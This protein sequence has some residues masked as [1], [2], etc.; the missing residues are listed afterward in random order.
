MTVRTRAAPSTTRFELSAKPPF[1]LDLTVWALRRRPRNAVDRWDDNT[2]R[3]ATLIGNTLA[4]VAVVQTGS[5]DAPR[6]AVTVTG[7]AAIEPAVARTAATSM[8]RRMLGLDTDLDDFYR[9]AA[10]DP[11]LSPL[12]RCFQGLKPPRFASLFEGRYRHRPRHGL[13]HA[14]P[15]RGARCLRG[16]ACDRLPADRWQR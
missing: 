11:D 13:D 10:R 3:R 6:L 7:A 2:Y 1:R 14:G 5:P 9:S 15:N 16:P 4:D 8:V 12:V